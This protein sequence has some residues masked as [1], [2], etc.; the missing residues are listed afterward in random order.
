LEAINKEDRGN[1][2]I[3]FQDDIDK[4]V[5]FLSEDYSGQPMLSLNSFTLDDSRYRYESGTGEHAQS[6]DLENQYEII[7]V[8]KVGNSSIKALWGGVFN[9]PDATSV[10]YS[11][12]DDEDNEIYNSKVNITENN[13]VYEKL[14]DGIYEQT[15]S[16]HYKILDEKNNVIVEW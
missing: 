7:R 12:K 16:L 15:Y 11:L 8:T 2:E 3:L 13:I 14:P 5:L 9:Y 6:I 10:S 4:V 1:V